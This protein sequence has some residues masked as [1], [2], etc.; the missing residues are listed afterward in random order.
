MY[1]IF[2]YILIVY[3]NAGN[4]RKI[5][6]KKPQKAAGNGKNIDFSEKKM[7]SGNFHNSAKAKIHKISHK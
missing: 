6:G 7:G 1:F 4:E 3:F 2:V 5:A